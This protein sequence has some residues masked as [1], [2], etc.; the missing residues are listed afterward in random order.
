HTTT[1]LRIRRTSNTKESRNIHPPIHPLIPPPQHR[2][3]IPPSPVV[4]HAFDR[5]CLE[6]LI[7]RPSALGAAARVP[8][9][10]SAPKAAR[11]RRVLRR[12][13]SLEG[14]GC[15]PARPPHVRPESRDPR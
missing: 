5:L 1:P 15:P 4:S 13:R 6:I 8:C 14:R 11:R 7:A 3:A 2:M 10:A 12:R 9:G